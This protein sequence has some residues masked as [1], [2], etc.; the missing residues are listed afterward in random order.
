MW[1]DNALNGIKY[2]KIKS[3]K[4]WAYRVCKEHLQFNDKKT[5]S[6]I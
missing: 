5:N 2:L 4:D 6:P 1:K 3:D